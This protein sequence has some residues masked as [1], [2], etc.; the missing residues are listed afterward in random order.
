MG[1]SRDRNKAG[2]SLDDFCFLPKSFSAAMSSSHRPL[3]PSSSALLTDLLLLEDATATLALDFGGSSSSSSEA[4]MARFLVFDPAVVTGG[5]GDREATFL[6]G[7]E[8]AAV[9]EWDVSHD[10]LAFERALA[11]TF[12]LLKS[13]L[14]FSGALPFSTTVFLTGAAAATFLVGAERR[15]LPETSGETEVP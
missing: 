12:A 15:S 7:F 11:L 13:S 6:T 9:C 8:L 1:A 2:S 5:D 14:P 3:R 4:T 10:S